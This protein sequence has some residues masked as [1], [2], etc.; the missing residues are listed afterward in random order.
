MFPLRCGRAGGRTLR[1]GAGEVTFMAEL[2]EGLYE[3]VTDLC[4]EGDGLAGKGRWP[5]AIR[6]Y[7]DAWALLPEPRIEWEAALWIQ[8]AIA[9]AHFLAGEFVLARE[10]LKL[11]LLAGGIGNPFVHLRR[12]QC[13]L[14]LGE[15]DEALQELAR[16]Y[17]CGARE[18]FARENPKYLDALRGVLEPPP[19]QR[20]L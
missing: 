17:A 20:D 14:E 5:E 7:H 19:G 16:A 18:V 9:D 15:R 10:P 8:T 6:R 12:G 4:A 3:Q 13:L 2:P 1:A 11:A